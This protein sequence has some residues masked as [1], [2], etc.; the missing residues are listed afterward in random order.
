MFLGDL[1]DFINPSQ[2]CVNPMFVSEDEKDENKTGEA[3]MTLN[4]DGDEFEQPD[5]IKSVGV[6]QKASVSLNDCLACSG[7]VTSA[8]TVLITMQ[9]MAEFEKRVKSRVENGDKGMAVVS[10]APQVRASIAVHFKMSALQVHR[11]LMSW[12]KGMGVD[13][14]VETSASGDVALL[15]ARNEFVTR[16]KNRKKLEWK[17]PPN[18]YANSSTETIYPGGEENTSSDGAIPMLTSACPG[19]VC[20]AEKSQQNSIPYI[21][22]TKSP[23]QIMG[24]LVKHVLG[25]EKGIEAKNIYHATIMPCFDKKLEASRKDFYDEVKDSDDVDTV[26]T[27]MEIL[28]YF[29]EQQIDFIAM[30][31]SMPTELETKFSGLSQDGE[32]ILGATSGQNGSGGYLEHIFRYAAKELFNVDVV[33]D[34]EYVQGRNQDFRQVSLQH[35]GETVLC[36]AQAYGFR[37][38]QGVLTKMKRSKCPYHFVEIMACPSGCLNGGG[39]IKAEKENLVPAVQSVY[40]D[41]KIRLPGENLLCKKVYDSNAVG[42]VGSEQAKQLFH[43]RY[44]AVPKMEVSNPLG[45]IW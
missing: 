33:G 8:E 9:S 34:L 37:N 26:L 41:R 36:F 29:T 40:S 10:I 30:E 1:N 24:S 28:D 32:V 25:K 2:A 14:V 12:L 22:T 5:L 42:G 35:H 23:Q 43:T 6:T 39:Q 13:L 7:C 44:H 15:E 11:K 17:H 16:F 27:S 38:I 31:E 45:I 19:W 18:S 20:Y 4:I 3:K 21:S